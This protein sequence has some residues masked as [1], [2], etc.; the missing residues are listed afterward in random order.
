[1]NKAEATELTQTWPLEPNPSSTVA[2][3]ALG[4]LPEQSWDLVCST[5]KAGLITLVW[6]DLWWWKGAPGIVSIVQKALKMSMP[7]FLFI[8]Q[9]L[10]SILNGSGH[11]GNTQ[12]VFAEWILEAMR[13]LQGHRP[14][15][16]KVRSQATALPAVPW[17]T[18][19]DSLHL[20]VISSSGT[21]CLT[22]R[23]Y[24]KNQEKRPKSAPQC[25]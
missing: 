10:L 21:T 25:G 24:V 18:V 1:M 4:Q 3:S 16:P 9:A 15:N 19:G 5:E 12:K 8:A 23:G 7:S 22:S 14:W 20:S 2:S 6:R 17:V 11:I 13:K